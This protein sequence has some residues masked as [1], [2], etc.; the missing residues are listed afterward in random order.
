MASWARRQSGLRQAQICIDY[1]AF[2]FKDGEPTK[3][4]VRSFEDTIRTID[5]QH[6][7][8]SQILNT[9]EP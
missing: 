8:S 5:N 9:I 3:K 4:C 6:F 7:K 1:A 2:L